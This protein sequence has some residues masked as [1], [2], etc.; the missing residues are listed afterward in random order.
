MSTL[1][2]TRH[3]G[4]F[5]VS[6]ANGTRSFDKGMLA[7]GNDLVAGAV[8]GKLTTTGEYVELDPAGAD[9]AE[10]ASGILNEAATASGAAV[11]IVA[12]ARDAEVNGAEIAWPAGILEA[13][14]TTALSQLA[15]LSIV[16]R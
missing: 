2:E 12:V 6:T 13:E 9:G 4:E 3:R 1:N 15:D 8:L 14:K 10:V 7:D 16:V 11:E 5:L